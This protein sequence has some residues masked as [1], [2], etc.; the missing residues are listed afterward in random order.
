MFYT[1]NPGD[2][3]IGLLGSAVTA[4]FGD[5]PTGTKALPTEAGYG[6]GELKPG[7]SVT[8]RFNTIVK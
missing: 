2:D 3:A 8:I 7:E 4:N 5:S 1:T 6:P